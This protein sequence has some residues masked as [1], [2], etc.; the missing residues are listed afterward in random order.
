MSDIRAF[1]L[2]EFSA[3]QTAVH[4]NSAP[5]RAGLSVEVVGAARLAG[6]DAAWTDLLTRADALNVFMDPALVRAAAEADP[7][8]QHGALLAWKPIGGRQ[9]L[10]G[11]WAFAI[12]H[13]PRSMLPMR[14]LIVP[15]QRHGHLATPVID[16]DCL[17]ETLDAMLDCIAA[18]PALPKD[19]RD[20]YDGHGRADL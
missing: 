12:G 3:A 6:I 17:D 19:C 11:V 9:Q 10:A 14:V 8:A 7:Q 20:R 13:A 5:Q 18:D 4:S 1:R 15:R 2:Q 16:R